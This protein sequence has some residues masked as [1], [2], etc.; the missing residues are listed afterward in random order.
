MGTILEIGNV[1]VPVLLCVLAGF[2]L[3]RLN[4]PFDTKMVSSLVSN[5]GYPTL[6]LSHLEGQPVS[7][8]G[9]LD[10]MLSAAAVVACFGVVGFAF[11]RAVGLTPRAFLSPMMLNNVGNIG[12]PVS[13]LA[14]GD[15]GLAYALGF[16]VVVMIGIFTIGIWL[17]MG[18][19]PVSA[20]VKRP[21]IYAVLIAIV[22]MAT[23]TRLPT[24][25]DRTFSILGGLAIPLMLLTLGHTL[26]TLRAGSLW[27]G[28]YLA[29]FHLAMAAGVAFA[30][31]HLFGFQGTARGTF[32]LLCMMPVSVATYLWVE[33][34][35]PEH[36]PDVAGFILL[37][38]ALAVVVLPLV[39]V[40]W[41]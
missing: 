14:F 1:L 10:M 31:V 35:A 36:A 3:A 16:T 18:K 24:M 12:I 17:P 15:Q 38:T 37:S 23:N 8:A 9:F 21:V 29:G 2:A 27:R 5:V 30:L 26:A 41:I 20:L 28:C 4:E 22:L 40:Y 39:L 19:V 13:S 34:Y 25:I 11:L 7:L 6:I 33:I 32:I